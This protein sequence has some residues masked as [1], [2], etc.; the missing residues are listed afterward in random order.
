MVGIFFRLSSVCVIVSTDFAVSLVL[1]F[2]LA[3][4]KFELRSWKF[5]VCAD[6]LLVA[7][8]DLIEPFAQ[9]IP[10]RTI[11]NVM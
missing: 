3:M 9:L 7:L 6:C 10:V 2:F 8:S 4:G 11:K 5:E 1:G